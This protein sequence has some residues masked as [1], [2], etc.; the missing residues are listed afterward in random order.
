ML[1]RGNNESVLIFALQNHNNYKDDYKLRRNIQKRD[2]A[3]I[4]NHVCLLTPCAT[5]GGYGGY[6]LNSV[7]SSGKFFYHQF[8]A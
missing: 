6:T 2:S 3:L 5:Y 4:Q 1:Q 8:L 7:S